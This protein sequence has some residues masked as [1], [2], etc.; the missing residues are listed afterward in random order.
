M[1]PQMPRQKLFDLSQR[2]A[3][4]LRSLHEAHATNCLFGIQ[5]IV[6]RRARRL[7]NNPLALVVSK[8]LDINAG[9]LRDGANRQSVHVLVILSGLSLNPVP[10]YRVKRNCANRYLQHKV[11]LV[12]GAAGAALSFYCLGAKPTA[13]VVVDPRAEAGFMLL[14]PQ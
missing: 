1:A 11:V 2:K 4:F 10:W 5:A 8:C 3:K 12:P 6:R 14:A 13:R 9:L 7:R